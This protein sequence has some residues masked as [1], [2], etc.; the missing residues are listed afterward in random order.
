MRRL[1][2]V[3]AFALALPTLVHAADNPVAVAAKRT[4]MAKS[5]TFQMS[6][7]TTIPGQ[8]KM[9]L[10][11]SGAQRGTSAKMTMRAR[12]QGKAFRF[13]AVLLSEGGSYVVY[14]RSP[15]FQSQLPRGKSWIRIDLSRQAASLGVDVT[16]LLNA[17]QSSAPLE[18]GLVSTTRVRREVVAG[19]STTRYR[20]VLDVKRAA[21][22]LPS[23]GRQI[24]AI[25]RA[26]GIRL[27]RIPYVVWI[28]GDRR[29]RRVRYS[30]PTAVGG[31]RGTTV[32]TVTFLSYDTPVT[33]S[34]P[35]RAQVF[36]P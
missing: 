22:A 3:C 11:G 6:V 7:A 23:Y 1:I 14:M 2:A 32:A 5:V 33:I 24:A 28:A 21:R 29:F 16:S 34:A 35:P 36:S 26:T 25:E 4:A 18:K 15:L 12:V 31:V 10:T 9:T 17:S 19:R 30:T 8:G 27:R 13:D 20:A